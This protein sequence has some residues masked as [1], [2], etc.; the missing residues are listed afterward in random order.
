MLAV[1]DFDQDISSAHS[2]LDTG[3]DLIHLSKVDD[4]SLYLS[5]WW[6]PLDD[7]INIF[8]KVDIPISKSTV[9][10][11]IASGKTALKAELAV[12]GP[13]GDVYRKKSPLLD[14]VL[15]SYYLG[16]L[17][18][19]TTSI[20]KCLPNLNNWF[21]NGTPKDPWSLCGAVIRSANIISE[22]ELQISQGTFLTPFTPLSNFG[23]SIAIS[24]GLLDNKPAIAVGAPNEEQSGSVYVIPLEE[25]QTLSSN[26]ITSSILSVTSETFQ[27]PKRFGSAVVK[28]KLLDQEFLAVSEPGTS[29]IYLY[30]GNS[31]VLTITD[32]T[33]QSRYGSSG[34]KQEGATI[35]TYDFDGDS[36]LDLIICSPYSDDDGVPQRG[37]IHILSGK[38]LSLLLLNTRF[39]QEFDIHALEYQNLHLPRL[40]RLD[41]GYEQFGTRTAISNNFIFTTANGPGVVLALSK[42]GDLKHSIFLEQVDG[43][44]VERKPSKESFRFGSNLILTGTYDDTEYLIISAHAYTEGSCTGCGALFVYKIVDDD[45]KFVTRLTLVTA[46]RHSYAKFGYTAVVQD[47]KLYISAPRYLDYGA[48]FRISLGEV[49][50]SQREHIEVKTIVARNPGKSYIGFGESL[51]SMNGKL[52]IGAPYY[53]F[54]SSIKDNNKLTG[55]VIIYDI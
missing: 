51:A 3:A 15:E 33:A 20:L 16:G 26:N 32:F 18:E 36:I 42:S 25:I 38:R 39:G 40:Y 52:A 49:L 10:Y 43:L 24:E 53:G 11:C 44:L 21:E 34:V 1:M 31:R 17:Q 28:Y 22:R 9:R 6:Y 12:S 2:F 54:Q 8:Q 37:V 5:R 7:I 48:V 50:N 55:E 19:I 23:S 4:L 30:S 35:E 29:S 45:V 27:I 41:G 46:S 13:A 47:E 14:D